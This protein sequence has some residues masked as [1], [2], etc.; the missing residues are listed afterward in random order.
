LSLHFSPPSGW[1]NDPNGLVY[2]D[3]EYHL[4]YQHYPHDLVWGPMHWGHAISRDLMSWKHLPIALYPDQHGMIY[5]GSAVIDHLGGAGF[6]IG[7]MVAVFT[8]HKADGGEE[9]S[10]AGSSDHGR[11][12][13]MHP[14]NPVIAN[15]SNL[16]DFRDPKVFWYEPNGHWV[17]VVA[18]GN[19]LYFYTSRNLVSWQPVSQF[20]LG[21][22]AH[23]GLW[24]TPELFE[25]PIDGEQGSC[26]VLSVGLQKGGPAGGSATQ[27]FFG[28]FDGERFAC[29]D[30]PATVHWAD[31]G[32]DFYAAQSW[33]NAPDG[34]RVWVA[35]MNNWDYA[36]RTPAENARG[37][38][39]LP[40]QLS[41]RRAAGKLV[42]VQK[43]LD[44]LAQCYRQT[45]DFSTLYYETGRQELPGVSGETLVVEAV[46]DLQQ[47]SADRFGFILHAGTDAEV[48]FGCDRQQRRLYVDRGQPS[49]LIPWSVDPIL[50]PLPESPANM[51]L[52]LL[53]DSFSLEI[54]VQEGEISLTN[55]VYPIAEPA[56]VAV[57]TEH[58]N[59]AF[60]SLQV[61]RLSLE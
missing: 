16:P 6:G 52:H 60:Q 10:L 53:L 29:R 55:L 8:R 25:L 18:G 21:W 17:M 4:F 32:S 15:P 11:T 44:E 54:F 22:G 61:H 3:G 42:L 2:L 5:S 30:E 46:I 20:G 12:W 24:E 47:T 40:R 27:L 31:W 48:R 9:Q 41:L 33:N 38:L 13:Q 35:W 51:K 36:L 57:F 37:L 58:G 50:A 14:A 19:R 1:L 59:L 43:P 49:G 56:R 23:G 26:W 28:D 39:S 45:W 7:A 34:R